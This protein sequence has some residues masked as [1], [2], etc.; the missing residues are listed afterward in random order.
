M[1]KKIFIYF[2]AFILFCALPQTYAQRKAIADSLIK[3]PD[4][5]LKDS[6]RLNRFNTIGWNLVNNDPSRAMEYAGKAR[7]LAIQILKRQE[8]GLTS[9]MR[10]VA[11]TYN[12]IGTVHFQK[13]EFPDAAKNYLSALVIYENLHDKS[14][15]AGLYNNLGSMNISM[16]NYTEGEK[17]LRKAMKISK[18]LCAENPTN[19]DYKRSL[20]RNYN[21]LGSLFGSLEKRDSALAYFMLSLKLKEEIGDARGTAQ[22]RCNIGNVYLQQK[23]YEDAYDYF[24]QGLAI[25]R[26]KEDR[27]GILEALNSLGVACAYLKKF[28]EGSDAFTEDL[29][30]AKQ[31]KFNDE[32]KSAYEGFSMLYKEMGDYQKSNEY[33][34]LFMGTKDTIQDEKAKQESAELQTKYE[35]GKKEATIELLEQ[36]GRNSELASSRQKMF[37]YSII[38]VLVMVLVLVVVLFNRNKLKQKANTE[39]GRKNT[40]IEKQKGEVEHQKAMVEEKQK[41]ILD[42][43]HYA[44]RIQRAVITSDSYIAAHL[45]EYFTLYKPKDIVSGDFYWALKTNDTFY[46]ITAD[47]TGHGVPGAFMSLL[48][49]SILNEIV[50]ERK[51]TRPDLI[52]NEARKDIIKALNPVGH[53][54]AKDGMD[55][56][57]CAFNFKTLTLEYASANNSFYILRK[58][59]DSEVATSASPILLAGF[60]LIICPPDKMPVGKSPKDTEPFTLRTVQLQKGDI[61]YTLTDGLADQFGGPKGKKFKYKKLQELIAA[62]AHLPM[63]EQKEILETIMEDWRGNLEQVDDML[64]IGLR[65]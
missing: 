40:L 61:I 13:G 45:P 35:S 20:S 24:T 65:V 42:S 17:Y 36:K 63:P 62:N 14:K 54:D 12:T 5:N 44:G 46:L 43:I 27:T 33:L 25:F 58:R 7:V 21:N 41:E 49:I 15:T 39:L 18:A 29:N 32:V 23:R 30:L 52:L 31:F 16:R 59:T 55:C 48:N 57:L 28:K 56:I 51:I 4:L 22:A 11:I 26:K 10:E 64:L 60:E 6:V 19:K 37:I 47:C 34:Y 50:I 8:E 9:I 38:F 3:L 1:S 2:I 53:E